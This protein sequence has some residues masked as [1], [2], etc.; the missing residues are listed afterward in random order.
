MIKNKTCA[1]CFAHTEEKVSQA[2]MKIEAPISEETLRKYIAYS[3]TN[4]YPVTTPEVW[5]CIKELYIDIRSMKSVYPRSPV[6][7]TARSLEAM[8]RT[9]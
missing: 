1:K 5:E 3:Q 8:Q 4:V 7:I 2:K 6:S 9:I